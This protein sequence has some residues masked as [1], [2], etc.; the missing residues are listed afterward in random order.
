MNIQTSDTVFLLFLA[1]PSDRVEIQINFNYFLG[2][3][4]F[5]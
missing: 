2:G 4:F 3:S 5:L 1:R